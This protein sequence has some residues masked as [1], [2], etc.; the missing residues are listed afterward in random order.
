[1]ANLEY[2]SILDD[3]GRAGELGI[4]VVGDARA[5]AELRLCRERGFPVQ[6][7]DGA[8]G[9]VRLEHDEESLVPCWIEQET[10]ALAWRRLRATGFLQ[11]DSTNREAC[12]AAVSGA[13]EGT[14]IFA[15]T[16]TA[17]KGRM[18]RNWFSPAGSG[19]YFSFVLRPQQPWRFWPLLTHVAAVA[20]I[21]AL[22]ELGQDMQFPEKTDI[23]LKWPNDV[24]LSG[25]K[26]AGILLETLTPAEGEAAAVIGVGVN[27]RRGSVPEEL[28]DVATC[29]DD[30][31][32]AAVPRRRV[33]TGFL[34]C[35][36][37]GYLLFR[38]GRFGEVLDRWKARS[39]MWDGAAV[40]VF[41]G[42]RARDAVTCGLDGMG[43]LRVRFADGAAETVLAG[44]IRVRRRQGRAT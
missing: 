8:P 4:A 22:R 16:Q 31:A 20:L 26:C 30:M 2:P 6:D 23:D 14:L 32:G 39:S 40:T 18:E 12:D 9:R 25:K 1:M 19:V 36:Q 13:E 33:M 10:R 35:F 5:Q 43:A 38:D 17:G 11:I 24:L 41:E 28:A 42:G 7:V 37:E 15:E 27:V 3:L 34:D 21:D 44:D 29:L